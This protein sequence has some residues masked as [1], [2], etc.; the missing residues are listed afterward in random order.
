MSESRQTTEQ[1]I[2]TDE[3]EKNAEIINWLYEYQ[4]VMVSFAISQECVCVCACVCVCVSQLQP[5]Q[6]PPLHQ[7]RTR[8]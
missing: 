2:C 7:Q 8:I 6:G 5:Y 1:F 4:R 3:G